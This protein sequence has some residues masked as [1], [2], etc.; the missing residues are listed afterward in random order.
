VAAETGDKTMV[1]ALAAAVEAVRGVNGGDLKVII[2]AVARARAPAARRPGRWSPPPGGKDRPQSR[3]CRSRLDHAV[4]RARWLSRGIDLKDASWPRTAVTSMRSEGWVKPPIFLTST[5]ARV[6][7]QGADR[8]GD[9]P[10]PRVLPHRARYRLAAGSAG[11]VA[12][13]RQRADRDHQGE[14]TRGSRH[15]AQSDGADSFQLRA[16][17][18]F[19]VY[20]YAVVIY[21]VLTQASRRLWGR[22]ERSLG[23]HL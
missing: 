12:R 22:I 23:R 3:P 9:R 18:D 17:F 15:A 1:D 8:G 14:R 10:R 6:G 20:L 4:T 19:S 7:R 13:A 2:A 16:T 5:F 11:G 21:L